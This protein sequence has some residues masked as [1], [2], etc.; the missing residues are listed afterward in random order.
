MNFPAG[1][2]PVDFAFTIHSAIGY[3]MQGARIN[4][5]IVPLDYQ[6]QNGD[7]VEIITSSA[8]HGPSRDWLKIVKTSQAR[9][10]INQWF[11]KEKREENIV[12]GKEMLDKEIKRL[13][14]S[15]EDLLNEEY[16]VSLFKRYGF[17]TLDD[18][19]CSIGYGSLP[20][21]KVISRLKDEHRKKLEKQNHN[22]TVESISDQIPQSPSNTGSS[23]GVVVSGIDNC[24]IRYSK[25]CNPVP[26]D[27]IIGYITRG[28]GVS[29]HRQDCTNIANAYTVPEEKERL[30]EVSWA[31]S[32]KTSFNASLKLEANDRPN[33]LIDIAGVIAAA[34]MPIKSMNA[35]TKDSIAIID[36]TVEI[37]D[38]DQISKIITKLKNIKDVI[39]VTRH[40]G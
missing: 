4:G 1:A 39:D 37:T 26:G 31:Q 32:E 24:L 20:L 33:M 34:K 9:S 27:K 21:T 18:L 23:D 7:I 12:R 29:I 28:R 22:L 35:R 17:A 36:I 2:T 14:L 13:G 6:L 25:C 40:N 3:K 11:K 8:I 19:Y 38:A 16:M 10:K 30:I 5:K 15:N